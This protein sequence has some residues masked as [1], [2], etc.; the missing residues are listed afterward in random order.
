M[1]TVA[2]LLTLTLAALSQSPPGSD[3]YLASLAVKDG[4]AVVGTPANVTHRPGY[5]NQPFFL[6]K[7]DAFLYTAVVDGQA[8]VFRYDIASARAVRVTDTPESE[9]SPTPLPDGSGF[10]VVR[11]E[12]DS[13]QRLWRFD[14]D[15]S[16]A[17]LVL[18]GVKPVGYHAWG[19]AHTAALFVLGAPP[20]LQIAD[21]RTGVATTLAADIGRGVQRIPGRAAVSY[22]LKGADSAW[23][24]VELD[25]ATRRTHPLVP[26]LRGVDQYAWTP[27]GVLL[28]AK[29]TKLYQW[30]AGRGSEWEEVA[31]FAGAGLQTITRLAVSPRGDRLAL[32]AADP[33]P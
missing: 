12:A 26:T 30:K 28:M 31:D 22:V 15:G 29:G 16:H 20:T 11:V 21:T 17:A 33:A 2:A 1:D 18:A 24:M 4:R 19:D 10:S 23:S 27:D 8:D 7:G 13:T 25:L 14:W 5:D 6:P 32:V 9:Y 3:I